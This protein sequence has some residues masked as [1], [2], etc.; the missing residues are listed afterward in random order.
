MRQTDKAAGR[1]SG[2]VG[3]GEVFAI[4][5][6]VL[7]VLAQR[8]AGA[9]FLLAIMLAASLFQGAGYGALLPL[10]HVMTGARPQ[11]PLGGPHAFFQRWLALFPD[12][13]QTLAAALTFAALGLASGAARIMAQ[14]FSIR[15]S[16]NLRG[17][18]M[19]TLM[20]RF[21]E[22][23]YDRVFGKKDGGYI[24]II[25]HEPS[26]ASSAVLSALEMTMQS[27]CALA[28]FALLLWTNWIATV[29]SMIAVGGVSF[30]LQKFCIG[31]ALRA[32]RERLALSTQITGDAAQ[33]LAGLRMI[34]A[35]SLE[36]LR[37]SE[38]AGKTG[39]LIRSL[40]VVLVM[41]HSYKPLL[42]TI[43]ILSVAGAVVILS[44]IAP[45]RTT[46]LFPRLGF[47]AVV[48]MRLLA[49][50]SE[51]MA[52]LTNM[53]NLGPSLRL[54][55]RELGEQES[56]EDLDSGRPF[57]HLQGDIVFENV[58]FSHEQGKPLFENLNIVIR[59][60][61]TTVLVGPSGGGK[62][63]VADLLLGLHRPMGGRILVG[64]NTQL[65]DVRLRDW[66]K[67]IG[68]VSQDCFLFNA[69]VGEN[70]RMAKPGA[71]QAEIQNAVVMANAQDFLDEYPACLDAEAGD[72]G[73]RFSA[74][75]RQRLTIARALLRDPD[76]LILDEATSALD[77]VSENLIRETL[78]RLKGKKTILL[79][80]H[81]LA[82]AREA[83][84]IYVLDRG[85]V[86]EEGS[87][88][89]LLERKGLFW[90]LA[91]AAE[92]DTA[93]SAR[94]NDDAG[95]HKKEG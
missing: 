35:F 95:A 76:I 56:Q 75:Q 10:L 45:D 39:R 72:R 51:L 3:P 94:R 77:A 62:T 33:N 86:V 61:R 68:F 12:R 21:L 54:M 17:M 37:L 13:Q 47:F 70:L 81:R 4:L 26:W 91:S 16:M 65:S 92:Q 83:D 22:G 79:I 60:L 27:V 25:I 64:P 48:A 58:A 29:A 34:K 52:S 23:R 24:N 59:H 30:I 74:G 43:A 9:C 31:P 57:D 38:F 53:V 2:A 28:L 78:Q 18:W 42:E 40:V 15:F 8:K 50:A 63:T 49:H 93:Q 66:R 7:R 88:E 71:T 6:L 1:E 36:K 20:Q 90:A 69:T 82:T 85:R 67:R 80:A 32:G 84:H 87:Y 5:R 41:R 55:E 46:A 14:Y 19:K 73:E 89:E 44:V 11:A